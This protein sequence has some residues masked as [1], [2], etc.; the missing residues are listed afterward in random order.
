MTQKQPRK[1]PDTQAV[2]IRFQVEQLRALDAMAKDSFMTRNA[3]VQL[4]VTRLLK[5]GVVKP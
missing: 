1:S 2:S 5:Q 4:A 3:L